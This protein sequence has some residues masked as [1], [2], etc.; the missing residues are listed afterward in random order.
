M[1]TQLAG[2]LQD[3]YDVVTLTMQPSGEQWLVGNPA[4]GEFYQFP[5]EGV[6]VLRL[7][8]QGQNL[9]AIKTDCRQKFTEHMDVDEFVGQLLEIGFIHPVTQ[10]RTAASAAPPVRTGGTIKF[11]M[12]QKVARRFF[13]PPALLAY[14]IIIGSALALMVAEPQLRPNFSALY[15]PEHLSITL[16][17]LLVLYSFMS[18]LHEFGHLIATA[19]CGV[20][21]TLG[22]G[23]RLWMIVAEA[24]LTNI[25]TLPQKQRYLPLL[26]GMAVD[27]LN[28]CAITL[29]IATLQRFG[30]NAF[31]IHLLQALIL[32]IMISISWQFN[33][34]LKTDV[35][36][37][38]CNYF[39]Y[40]DLDLEA[41]HYIRSLVHKYSGGLLG[42]KPEP[43]SYY[44][45]Q[46]LRY[47]TAFWIGGRVLALSFFAAV[48][49]PTLSGYMQSFYGSLTGSTA[50]RYS[51]WDLGMFVLIS[52]ALLGTGMYMW[53]FR[54]LTTR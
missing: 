38:L 10:T 43:C 29:L 52:S 15:F 24:D 18:L 48:I 26:A 11:S 46:V 53:L 40:P 4:E 1:T 28:I 20:T 51:A 21:S 17:A 32:Q 6:H 41:R 31:A 7:L 8:Q 54:R 30:V 36:F 44:R 3:S 27:C 50:S 35:Y 23:N 16:V 22:L 45:L 33:F 2:S 49:I 19:R 25:Y 5:S 37:L 13:S 42:R 39:S 9:D 14:L 47:F 34:F 12:Q